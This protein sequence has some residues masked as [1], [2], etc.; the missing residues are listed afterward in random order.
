MID[1]KLFGANDPENTP[2]TNPSSEV[3]ND[4]RVEYAVDHV[5]LLERVATLENED[6]LR[7]AL[8]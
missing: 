6:A 8:S 2:T 1:T 7:C 3:P 5:N 4:Q